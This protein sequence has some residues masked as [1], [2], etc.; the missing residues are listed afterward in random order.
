MHWFIFEHLTGNSHTNLWHIYSHKLIF[1][2]YLQ[3]RFAICTSW[4]KYCFNNFAPQYTVKCLNR[5]EMNLLTA[6]KDTTDPDRNRIFLDFSS[7]FTIF[8]F[9]PKPS[10]KCWELFVQISSQLTYFFRTLPSL[11]ILRSYWLILK[12]DF[13]HHLSRSLWTFK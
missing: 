6:Y 13:I 12:Y 10:E 8:F 9:K 3:S 11:P 5:L 1:R 2:T 7:I 4:N